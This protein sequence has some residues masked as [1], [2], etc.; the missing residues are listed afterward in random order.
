MG[1]SAG[2]G[3]LLLAGIPHH[4]EALAALGLFA[5]FT[6]VSMALA[7]TTFGLALSR[8]AIVRSYAVVAPAL[9]ACSLAFGIWYAL[10]ALHAV[11]Y[12]F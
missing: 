12:V 9:G 10:G 7:S 11:P 4:A 5:F 8:G 2:I 3:V 1:G 6:A